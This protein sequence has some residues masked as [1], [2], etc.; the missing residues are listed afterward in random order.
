M[1]GCSLI[2]YVTSFFKVVTAG[3][4]QAQ[5]IAEMLNV[6]CNIGCLLGCSDARIN[7]YE[8][9]LHFETISINV[10]N[11]KPGGQML[12]HPVLWRASTGRQRLL[13]SHGQPMQQTQGRS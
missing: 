8:V 5:F 4:A 10:K 13:V 3:K 7:Q 11:P 12:Y 2:N 6:Q 1:I 9:G